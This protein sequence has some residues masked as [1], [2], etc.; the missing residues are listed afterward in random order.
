MCTI[1][2]IF[3][4]I[5]HCLCVGIVGP[6]VQGHGTDD[7]QL[8]GHLL[9]PPE[10]SLLLCVSKLHHQAGRGTLRTKHTSVIVN[11]SL[12]VTTIN[13]HSVM[14]T[15]AVTHR[16]LRLLMYN[17]NIF[18]QVQPGSFLASYSSSVCSYFLPCLCC[19]L[20]AI[21]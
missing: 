6:E 12:V 21:K 20:P 19:T 4:C 15:P 7:S 5:T 10:P 8:R 18:V 9:H 3:I 1:F 2:R 16:C 17:P 13:H 14:L 11:I